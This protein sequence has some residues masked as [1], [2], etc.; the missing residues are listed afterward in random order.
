MLQYDNFYKYHNVIYDFHTI[1]LHIY[2]AAGCFFGFKLKYKMS[3]PREAYVAFA[4]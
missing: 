2:F 1:L 3:S 4:T